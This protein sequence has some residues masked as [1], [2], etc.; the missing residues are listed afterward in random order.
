[1]DPVISFCFAHNLLHEEFEFLSRK[2]MS[3]MKRAELHEWLLARH[4]SESEEELSTLKGCK[5]RLGKNR[6]SVSM[7]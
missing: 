1:M 5:I 4:T 2:I 3:A 6:E 7:Q